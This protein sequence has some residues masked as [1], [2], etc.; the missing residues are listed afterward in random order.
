MAVGRAIIRD[1]H[2][3]P[4]AQKLMSAI[5]SAVPCLVPI[6]SRPSQT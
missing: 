2:E 6:A 4:Q 3:G 5:T 1:L